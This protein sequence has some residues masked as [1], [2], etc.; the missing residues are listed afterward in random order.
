MVVMSD[1]ERIAG[2]ATL[3]E[4]AWNRLKTTFF[5]PEYDGSI[6]PQEVF[7]GDGA[8]WRYY[9]FE[10]PTGPAVSLVRENEE[11]VTSYALHPEDRE[12]ALLTISRRASFTDKMT[13]MS[14]QADMG[15]TIPTDDDLRPLEAF[16]V[17]EV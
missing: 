5:N 10:T 13:D 1:A 12:V 7:A 6:M 15:L 3:S 17:P 16:L 14:F 8:L 11:I 4:P 2:A 9:Y